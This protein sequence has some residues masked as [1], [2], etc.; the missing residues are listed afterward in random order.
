[1]AK[2]TV[3]ER[4]RIR[5]ARIEGSPPDEIAD[6][7]GLDVAEVESAIAEMDAEE[8]SDL[9]GRS[10]EQW[11]LDYVRRS[12]ANLRA[13][14][15]L[16]VESQG[17]KA[18]N[19]STAVAAIKARQDIA[20]KVIDRGQNLGLINRKPVQS[21]HRVLLGRLDDIAL[22]EHLERELLTTRR[23]LASS[24]TPM[25]EVTFED[26]EATREHAA[27]ARVGALERE[28][29]FRLEPAPSPRTSTAA[30]TP[31]ASR[32]IGGGPPAPVTRRKA[33]AAK[34]KRG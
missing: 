8:T 26:L 18:R 34:I 9:L 16:I 27:A 30:S 20:D 1:M 13:L 21:E 31:V 23:L 25:L 12:N 4:A 11:F 14:D 19:G 29:E 32:T 5:A 2:L 28:S 17:D 24:G 7:M 3:K 10:P 33:V 6:A 15:G 22:V